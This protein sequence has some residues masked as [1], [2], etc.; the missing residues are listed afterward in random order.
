MELSK[1]IGLRSITT[2]GTGACVYVCVCVSAFR[3][4]F[5]WSSHQSDT[6]HIL[7]THSAWGGSSPTLLGQS[8][9][10]TMQLLFAV[11]WATSSDL[12]K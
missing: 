9:I 7:S 1:A 11:G 6:G 2:S 5:C 12:A 10:K 4:C 3:Y 8:N